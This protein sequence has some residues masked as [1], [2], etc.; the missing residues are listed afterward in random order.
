MFITEWE[1]V[2]LGE[3]ETGL[4]RCP[5]F[6]GF[7]RGTPSQM[8]GNLWLQISL[9]VKVHSR[10]PSL[11]STL[12]VLCSIVALQPH[13]A[14]MTHHSVIESFPL[15]MSVTQEF[16]RSTTTYDA[17]D[18]NDSHTSLPNASR[19]PCVTRSLLLV[20]SVT[21]DIPHATTVPHEKAQA[22]TPF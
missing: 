15:K 1:S 13:I 12:M 7:R 16:P 6:A 19:P 17:H 3:K 11:L 4:Q 21:A 2:S 18:V 9:V 8:T 10:H 5:Y 14:Q 20:T 22:Q